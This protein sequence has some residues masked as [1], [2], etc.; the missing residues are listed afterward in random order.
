MNKTELRKLIL[1]K[2]EAL[3]S[4]QRCALLQ[5][6]IDHLNEFDFSNIKIVHIYLPIKKKNEIDTFPIIRFLKLIAP[7][8]KIVIPKSDFNTFD[9]ESSSATGQYYPQQRI[10]NAGLTVTF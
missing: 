5:Q 1:E 2:R 10:V 8:L 3:S 6:V 7:N 9:P 4:E